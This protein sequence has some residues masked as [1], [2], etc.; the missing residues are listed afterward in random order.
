MLGRLPRRL[1]LP[2]DPL[3][4]VRPPQLQHYRSK[5]QTTIQPA[6]SVSY[7]TISS[8]VS[9]I[10]RQ[11]SF[12]STTTANTRQRSPSQ[13]QYKPHNYDKTNVRLDTL[14]QR[15]SSSSGSSGSSGSSHI[16]SIASSSI[17]KNRHCQQNNSSLSRTNSSAGSVS[18][19]KNNQV[20]NA[21]IEGLLF[22]HFTYGGEDIQ[23]FEKISPPTSSCSSPGPVSTKQRELN[24]MSYDKDFQLSPPPPS[25]RRASLTTGFNAMSFCNNNTQQ[26]VKLTRTPS[27][28]SIIQQM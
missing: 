1:N 26:S 23:L 9:N 6:G 20:T 16:K 11:T 2:S 13:S 10:S 22:E 3:N 7:S 28:S 15:N 12:T 27:F 17:M 14:K 24:L 19:E 21:S 8:R 4:D 5:S 18:S 25:K